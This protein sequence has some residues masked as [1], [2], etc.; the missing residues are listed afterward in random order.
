MPSDYSHLSAAVGKVVSSD[1]P[2]G[3]SELTLIQHP[4]DAAALDQLTDSQGQPLRMTPWVE[5]LQKLTTS[6]L[7][8]DQGAGDNESEAAL[9]HGPS[10]IMGLRSELRGR[11]YDAGVVIDPA[12]NR[13]ESPSQDVRFLVL[14]ARVD[15]VCV[16][17]SWQTAING[18]RLS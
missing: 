2:G 6:S 12:G 15:F 11:L 18:I 13:I 7:R 3:A 16:R 9:V 8:T 14:T 1:F 10:C 5:S 4:Q 17:P